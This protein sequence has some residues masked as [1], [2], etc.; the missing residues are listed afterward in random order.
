M[1]LSDFVSIILIIGFVLLQL[2]LGKFWWTTFLRRPKKKAKKATVKKMTEL[3][4]RIPEPRPNMVDEQWQSV[5]C[6]YCGET[7]WLQISFKARAREETV[8]SGRCRA[9]QSVQYKSERYA[10]KQEHIV[11]I[12]QAFGIN[13]DS[14]TDA[15]SDSANRRFDKW[16]DVKDNALQQCWIG[17][18]MW[19]NPPWSMWPEVTEKVLKR[20]AD[21]ICICPWWSTSWLSRLMKVASRNIFFGRGARLFELDGVP[22]NGTRWPV[23]VLLVQARSWPQDPG[24]WRMRYPWSGSQ[25][26]RWKRQQ[27]MAVD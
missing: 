17:G 4:L 27:A 19:C 23:V 26:R 3:R 9:V 11:R 25:R 8:H 6:I 14:V 22:C 20:E 5:S 2:K 1:V 15:F 21:C 24:Y 12:L 13:K 16:I 18:V 7:L 10:V